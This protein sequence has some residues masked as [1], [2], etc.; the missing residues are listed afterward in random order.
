MKL[1]RISDV[2]VGAGLFRPDLLLSATWYTNELE[3]DLAV[4]AGDLTTEG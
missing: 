4:V 1:G 3:P 2:H